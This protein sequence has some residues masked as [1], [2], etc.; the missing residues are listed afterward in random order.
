MATGLSP[1]V[2]TPS[3]SFAVS[4][5]SAR[6]LRAA[7]ACKPITDTSGILP[8]LVVSAAPTTAMERGFI[9]ASGSGRL[10]EGKGDGA[11]GLEG[12]L[13]GHVQLQ[14]LGGLRATDDV[15]HHAGTFG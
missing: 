11:E 8:S 7:S 9:G 4:P 12:H 10:E 13:D 3:I 15:G 14:S 2:A 5:A 1:A 6:V